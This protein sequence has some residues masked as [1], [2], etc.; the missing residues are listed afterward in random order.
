MHPEGSLVAVPMAS[1]ERTSHHVEIWEMNNQYKYRKLQ[2]VKGGNKDL[3]RLMS[4]Y[5]SLG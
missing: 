5:L 3:K 2:L 4:S 1:N